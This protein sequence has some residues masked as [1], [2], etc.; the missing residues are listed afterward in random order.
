MKKKVIGSL[1][2]VILVVSVVGYYEYTGYE[3][4][5]VST[6]VVTGKITND[7]ASGAGMPGGAGGIGGIVGGIGGGAPKPATT[8]TTRPSTS[9]TSRSTTSTASGLSFITI[10]VGTDSFTQILSCGTNAY[11]AGMSVQVA[12][13]LLRSGG[14]Q[15]AADV[16]CKGQV[17]AFKVLYP[18]GY[19]AT[20]STSTSTTT[21]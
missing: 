7:Q 13:Q 4:V 17:S 16:A 10:T 1:V 6:S 3:S 9:T 21:T 19:T 11:Y 14:H 15:Y 8:T 12:D 20:T 18:H 2:V 5:V